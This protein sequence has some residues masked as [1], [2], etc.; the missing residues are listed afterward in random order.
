[1]NGGTRQVVVVGAGISGLACAIGLRRRGVRA[2]VLE[3]GERA[4]GKIRTEER[5]GYQFECG[6]NT[7]IPNPPLLNLIEEAGLARDIVDAAPRAKRRFVLC[8]GTLEP[9]PM[10][11]IAA[12]RSPLLGLGGFASVASEPFR[13]RTG[14]N[15][16]ETVAAFIERRF[17][18]RILE[19][20]VSPFVSGIYAGDPKQ[21]E[22]RS[23][24]PRLVE[25]E[26][27]SGSVIRGLLATRRT[28]RAV[29][30]RPRSR[31]QSITLRHG[32]GSLAHALGERLGPNLRLN[33]AV[34]SIEEGASGCC[35]HLARG[36]VIPCQ[37]VVLSGEPRS[38]VA[39]LQGVADSAFIRR[40]L[41]GIEHAGLIVVGLGFDRR[42]VEHPLD[43]FGYLAGPGSKSRVLG[44]MFRSSLFPHA[45]PPGRC[46]IVSFVRLY[47]DGRALTDPAAVSLVR[48]ELRQRLGL[49]GEPEVVFASRWEGAIAQPRPGHDAMRRRVLEWSA[50]GRVS[51]ISSAVHGVSLPLCAAT[52]LAEAERLATL[53]NGNAAP[54]PAREIH[55]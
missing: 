10:G 24:F 13:R 52:G 27:R 26:R 14:P 48:Q 34:E 44:C 42:V 30:S 39:L 46:L 22:A 7:V 51:V 23:V 36:D 50:R 16:G 5:E 40:D 31:H 33:A 19:N 45:A 15:D 53:L 21:L 29:G 12:I 55:A 11:L 28:E 35:V 9:I 43:G 38:S 54:A 25:A 20:L 8:H 37:H 41:E 3:S 18:A 1:M 49:H 17:G 47:T 32:L 2:V 4:G 6:P